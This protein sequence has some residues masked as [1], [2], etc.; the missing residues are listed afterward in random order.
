MQAAVDAWLRGDAATL[1]RELVDP[2]KKPESKVVYDRLI[3]QR[4]RSMASKIEWYLATPDKYFVVVGSGHL[5]GDDS[6][7][8]ILRKNGRAVEQM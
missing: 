7:L 2:M 4:N 3:A 8:A 1:G 5:V 6:I